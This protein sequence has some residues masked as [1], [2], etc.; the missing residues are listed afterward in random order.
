MFINKYGGWNDILAG[1][2]GLGAT[3]LLLGFTFWLMGA[4]G[5][6]ALSK[7][8]IVGYWGIYLLT[9]A[10]IVLIVAAKFL[11]DFVTEYVGDILIGLVSVGVVMAGLIF[12]SR[13]AAG[14]KAATREGLI[15]LAGMELI[16]LGAMVVVLAAWGLAKLIGND[17]DKLAA[18]V[19]AAII[20]VAMFGVLAW[21]AGTMKETLIAGIGAVALVE[22]LA[23]GAMGV[24]YVTILLHQYMKQSGLNWG[25]IYIDSLAMLGIVTVWGLVAL[26]A[27]FVAEFIALGA[28]A[29][30]LI[31]LLICGA[32]EVTKLLIDLHN[33]MADQG[34]TWETVVNDVIGITD[35]LYEFGKF[36]A[37]AGLLVGPL[38]LGNF[39]LGLCEIVLTGAIG[40]AH[41]LIK[42]HKVKE[43][44]GVGWIELEKDVL[45]M[46]MILGTFAVLAAAAIPLAAPILLATPAMW[47]VS[48]FSVVV[49]A[50]IT[51]MLSIKKAIDVGGGQ[52]ALVKTLTQ[53]IPKIMQSIN[54]NNFS[55]GIGLIELG[56]L[57]AK[58]ALVATLM[59]GIWD[60]VD[61]ITKIAQLSG[62]VDEQ[63][64]I[65]PV[66]NINPFT[67]E[68]KYGEKVNLV[69]VSTLIGNA[70]RAFADNTQFTFQD[71]KNAFKSAIMFE[72]ISTMIDP[73]TK[74][75]EMLT[76]YKSTSDNELIPLYIDEQ[77]NVKTGEPVKV[78]DV[79][80]I[81][82]NTISAFVS[83][84][85]AEEHTQKWSEIMYGDKGFIARTLGYK[86]AKARSVEDAAG[87]LG[88][89]IEPI[90]KFI[91]MLV[92]LQA[93]ADGKK[94]AK[95]ELD[96]EGNVK[97][98]EFVDVAN[99]ASV[100]SNV[101]TTFV[102]KL[103]EKSDQWKNQSYL[104]GAVLAALI[105][106]ISTMI[107]Y[108][109]ELSGED[110]NVD[111][112]KSS[113]DAIIY[114][115]IGIITSLTSI[116]P[117]SYSSAYS[118][119]KQVLGIATDLT[120]NI[121]RQKILV[122]S[123]AIT[124]FVTD[125]VEKKFNKNIKTITTFAASI[126]SLKKQ[127]KDLDDILTKDE[128]KRERAMDNFTDRVKVIV[129]TLGESK[130]DINNFLE[131]LRKTEEFNPNRGGGTVT[132]DEN[133][134]GGG[135][136]SGWG[137]Q[138]HSIVDNA[139]SPPKQ[140]ETPATPQFDVTAL[141][142]AFALALHNTLNNATIDDNND[143]TQDYTL[144]LV[145]GLG[146]G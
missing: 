79:A 108:A 115:N 120:N 129:E 133:R 109:K 140:E 126:K 123:K 137:N 106:P 4:V 78:V 101:I 25:D 122:N 8:V 132:P 23:V 136:F 95:L 52:V 90:T 35:F 87:V 27:G 86:T 93:S 103:Y 73:I 18:A 76:H 139:V 24:V 80:N 21:A 127:F 128:Q 99:I 1:L 7:E 97:T 142:N 29:M 135:S 81:I 63:G 15:A 94:L 69:N 75:V 116:D 98:G 72:V 11:G 16:A 10:S 66:L 102:T 33:T 17:W 28:L 117:L 44:A 143:D 124:T 50:V 82:A 22:L 104:N 51:S 88:I 13:F 100:I 49:I 38:T 145:G 57:N 144:R 2:A 141:A 55:P 121:D 111:K 59:L 67:G 34:I 113:T 41:M 30:A 47:A 134:G 43:E 119:M 77:G 60:I 3:I 146:E 14:S 96:S 70:V 5:K 138:V 53:D 68:V 125:V 84:L 131:L 46:A 56:K 45:G 61:S 91:D 118:S 74:F 37:L 40:I 107:G 6:V 42:L 85:Y 20:V 71:I 130:H 62:A 32:I 19:G 58:Y 83:N 105:K 31:E 39:A 65:R 89:V 92:T 110:I 114:A 64:N 26:G 36:A 12:L 9:I 112:I 54:P 48:A